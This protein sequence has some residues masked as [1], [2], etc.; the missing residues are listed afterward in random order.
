MFWTSCI[1]CFFVWLGSFAF[2]HLWLTCMM[3]SICE[4]VESFSFGFLVV[5]T[6][7]RNIIFVYIVITAMLKEARMSLSVL[8]IVSLSFNILILLTFWI[9]LKMWKFSKEFVEARTI[10]NSQINY[11][12]ETYKTK[13]NNRVYKVIDKDT[14]KKIFDSKTFQSK[15]NLDREILRSYDNLDEIVGKSLWTDN[16]I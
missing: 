14:D 8:E 10:E 1:V 16:N 11:R 9:L 3:S 5:S 6:W 7:T 15:L 4:I 12:I 13:Q 2:I